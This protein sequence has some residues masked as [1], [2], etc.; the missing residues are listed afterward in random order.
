[1]QHKIA[2]FLSGSGSN[3]RN[4]CRYFEKHKTIQVSLL[5][6]NKENSGVPSIS[7]DFGIPYFIFNRE[8]FY[9]SDE[10]IGKLAH[11]HID[12]L[13]LAGFLWLIPD[14]LLKKY[15]N[16]IIN[17][18]PALLPKYGGKGMHGKHVHQAVFENK[19]KESGIT[20]HLCNEQYDDG[21]I[22]YQKSVALDDTD[23]AET[24]SKKVLQLE[25]AYFPKTIEEFLTKNG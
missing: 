10:I 5:L 25:H 7:Q 1:M 6:T 11:Y 22:L 19:E 20:I 2:I 14:S 3:A 23:T 9:N 13:I 4:I 21:K 12:T 15:P 17:I 8:Q 18:H 16:S 24:I